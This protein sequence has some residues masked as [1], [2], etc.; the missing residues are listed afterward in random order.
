MHVPSDLTGTV[1]GRRR[2]SPRHYRGTTAPTAGFVHDACYRRVEYTYS[3]GSFSLD[4]ALLYLTQTTTYR[5]QVLKVPYNL[6]VY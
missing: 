1:A 3:M 5:K 2:H 6:G 4:E